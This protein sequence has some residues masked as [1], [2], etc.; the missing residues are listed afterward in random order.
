MAKEKVQKERVLVTLD[1]D[2]MA[3]IG[4]LSFHTRTPVSTII[5]LCVEDAI[6]VVEHRVIQKARGKMRK[7]PNAADFERLSQLAE[8]EEAKA[9]GATQK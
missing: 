2:L 1:E 5:K 4:A 3:R 9:E 7:L 6:D 8:E